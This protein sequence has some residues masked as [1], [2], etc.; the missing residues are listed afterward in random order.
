MTV[1]VDGDVV[2]ANDDEGVNADV[3]ELVG[4][5]EPVDCGVDDDGLDCYHC[6]KNDGLVCVVHH[7]LACVA[8]DANVLGW[9][10]VTEMGKQNFFYWPAERI[11]NLTLHTYR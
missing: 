4:V 5:N 8:T 1:A 11:S 6:L 7:S 2:A 3:N 9:S 10:T